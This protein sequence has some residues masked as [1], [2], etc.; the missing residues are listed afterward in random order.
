APAGTLWQ[1]LTLG[2]L[3]FVLMFFL[4]D[5]PQAPMDPFHEGEHLTAG[6]LMKSGERPYGDFYIFHGLAVDAGLDALVLG[7]P[8]SP[9]RSRRLLTLLDAATMAL[10][11]PIA[12][13]VV[14]TGGALAAGVFLSMCATAAFWLPVFPYFRLAPP[15]LAVL[16]LLRYRRS[17]SR[18]WLFLAFAASTLG[19]LWSLDTGLYALAGTAGSMIVLRLFRL[20]EKPAPLSRVLVFAA[21]ALALPLV[22]LLAVRADLARF[23]VDSFVIM[24]K[25]IDAVWALAAPEPR[26]ANGVRY[27]LPLVFYGFALA[28]GLVAW[29]RGDKRTAANAA[30]VLLFSL[31]LFRTAAGRV[32][33]GHTRFAMPL[34]GVAVV[35]FA[36]E[37]LFRRRGWRALAG[38]ALCA[39]LFFYFEVR[40]NAVAGAKLVK[41]WRARQSTGGL[42]PYPFAHVRG[43]HTS[44]QNA[45][46]L[47]ALAAFVDTLGP[48][49]ATIFDFSN[50]RAL[51]YLLGRKSPARVLEVSMMSHPRVLAETMGELTA[52][53][54]VAVIVRGDPNIAAFDGV[55]NAA[56]VPDLAAWI[57]ANY[58]RRTEIGRFTVASK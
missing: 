12:A 35:A 9:L 17:G 16:G 20:E 15:L 38:V 11:V 36:L 30:I 13:E 24:P 42:V 21:V 26:S 5:H 48:K 8:P 40:E 52:N 55:P 50:E 47:A 45:A 19:V 25:A 31:L 27:Y 32:S 14:A 2:A 37:P 3:V 28:L 7:D 57:D 41:S 34:L 39:P 56:R 49:E 46:D 22:V 10:L 4:H 54:P 29:R 33:W 53:P 44:P 6:W 23:F 18:S 58:P 43:I 1:R 51:Y